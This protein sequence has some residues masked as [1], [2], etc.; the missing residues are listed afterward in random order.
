MRK[1]IRP[2]FFPW[3][4]KWRL[5][6][7]NGSTVVRVPTSTNVA[8]VRANPR[9]NAICA[10]SLLL[11]LSLAQRGFSPGT[12]AF[13]S[14]QETVF[15]NSHLTR[16]GKRRTT[17]WSALLNRCLLI[18][19]FIY[20]SACELNKVL[21]SLLV[22]SNTLIISSELFSLVCGIVHIPPQS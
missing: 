2:S 7:S 14:P 6:G 16:N 4:L 22:L 15:S 5:K 9:G 1:L 12:P 10:M 8:R 18:Y 11:V 3:F 20:L 13:P 21:L 19:L 17:L